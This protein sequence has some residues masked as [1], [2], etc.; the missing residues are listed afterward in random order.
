MRQR[1]RQKLSRR[2]TIILV[3]SAM[4]CMVIGL[5]IFFNLSRVDQSKAT[6]L[7]VIM[8]SDQVFTTEKSIPAPEINPQ[9]S[10]NPNA[11]HVKQAKPLAPTSITQ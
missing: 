1:Q 2:T 5:T 6:N 8:V 11:M 10:V 9:A 4:T 7:N 3:A